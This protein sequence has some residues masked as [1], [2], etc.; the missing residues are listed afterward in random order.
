MKKLLSVLA[1]VALFAA[2]SFAQDGPKVKWDQTEI[3]YGDIQQ[4]SDPLRVFTFK[5]VGNAPLLISNAKGSCGCTVPKYPTEAIAPGATGKIEV[6]YDTKRVG[7]FQKTVTI[8]TNEAE[9]T[10]TLTI[11]GKVNA[12]PTEESVP[13][14]QGGFNNGGK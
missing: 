7:P 2:V 14:S 1:V 4:D 8:T 9:A 11:K 12:K 13:A 10:H 6:R 3:N 5:N